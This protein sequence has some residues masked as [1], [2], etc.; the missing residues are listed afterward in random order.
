[1]RSKKDANVKKQ[2]AKKNI[3]NATTL[4]K[5][6]VNF[7]SVKAVKIADLLNT[8]KSS[9]TKTPNFQ[10]ILFYF[11]YFFIFKYRKLIK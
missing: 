3:V 8:I 5:L 1:M 9:P 10:I 11:I 6:V 2:N 7:V 4:D